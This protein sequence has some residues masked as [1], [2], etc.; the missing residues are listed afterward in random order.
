LASYPFGLRKIANSHY[1]YDKVSTALFPFYIF[2]FLQF[3]LLWRSYYDLR[4]EY[5]ALF[6]TCS[7]TEVTGLRLAARTAL[8][9]DALR[10]AKEEAFVSL[11]NITEN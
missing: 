5:T 10:L 7:E 2:P 1:Y 8:L 9:D 4:H 6:M 11:E 3:L